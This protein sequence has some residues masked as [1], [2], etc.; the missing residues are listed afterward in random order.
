MQ[1]NNNTPMYLLDARG[2][3]MHMLHRGSDMDSLLSE[4]GKRQINTAEFGMHNFI[5]GYLLP[6]LKE[7]PPQN[8][9]AVWDGGKDY[10]SY[11][12]PKY[13]ANRAKTRDAVETE[14]ADKLQNYAKRLLAYLGILNISVKGVEADD[15]L[16][17]LCQ[18]YKGRQKAVYTVDADLLQLDDECTHVFLREEVIKGDYKGTPLNLIRLQKSIVGDSSDGYSGVNRIGEV[19]WQLMVDNYGFDGLEELEHIVSTQNFEELRQIAEE[20]GCKV[21]NRLYE[22]RD[23]WSLMYDLARLHPELCYGMTG[24]KKVEPI[25]YKRVPDHAQVVKILEAAKC[26]NFFP[27]FED[28]W[29]REILV[30]EENIEGVFE[31]MDSQLPETPYV[32]FDYETWD[33]VKHPEF[34]K[35]KAKSAKKGYVDVLSSEIAG[36]SFNFGRNL[37]YTAYFCVDHALT[38]NVSK[39]DVRAIL[40]EVQNVHKVPLI[41]H[42]A[43]FEEQIS[44]QCLG[45]EWEKPHDTYLMSRYADENREAGLKALSAEILRYN[46]T[47]YAD[48]LAAAG[49]DSMEKLTGKQALSYGCDD[50]L[51]TTH[52]YQV[53]KLTQQMEGSWD[54]YEEYNTRTVNVLNRAKEI[55][56]NLDFDRLEELRKQDAETVISGMAELRG[57]LEIH[58]Q[59]RNPE[60]AEA[61]FKLER[62]V[63]RAKITNKNPDWSSSKLN[64]KLEEQRLKWVAASQYVPYRE[65]RASVDFMGT[66]NQLNRVI[67]GIGVEGEAAP[68]PLKSISLKEIRRWLIAL[69]DSGIADEQVLRFAN[70]LGESAAELKHRAGESWERLKDFCLPILSTDSKVIKEGDEL[71]LNSPPQVTELLYCK[72]ALPVREHTKKQRGSFRDVQGFHGSPATDEDAIKMAIAQDCEEGSWKRR[73]LE[74]ILEIKGCLTRESLYYSKYPLW[75]HPKTGM[76]HPNIRDCGT[77]TR[78]PTGGDPNIL[79]V[80]KGPLRSVFIPRYNDHV[81]VAIDFSG[82][83]LRITGAE[84]NDPTLIEAYTGAEPVLNS[85]GMLK[86]Q[87][88]D[89]HSVTGCAFAEEIFRRQMG[90]KYPDGL[91]QIGNGAVDYNQFKHI[92]DCQGDLKL[93][94]SHIL[95]VPASFDLN[96]VT[97]AALL[98]RKMAKTVNFL[99]IYGGSAMT[100]AKGL[101]VP[102]EFAERLMDMVFMLYGRLQPW[103]SE[104]TKFARTHGYVQTAY[105]NRRHCTTDIVSRDGS[106]RSRM[107]RQVIN[108]TIQSCAADI[109]HIVETDMDRTGLL[110]ET[111]AVLIAPIYDEVLASVPMRNLFEYCERMQDIMNVT[112]PGH[113]IPQLAEVSVGPNWYEV[114]EMGDRPSEQELIQVVDRFDRLRNVA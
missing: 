112:P 105:G 56:I 11:L 94:D 98:V 99:I 76:L 32:A 90:S 49:V 6:I 19:A 70:L 60:G 107:E 42:N 68:E 79:Q 35:A 51:V 25:F 64:V 113:V 67:L 3:V 9:I 93:L 65:V 33:T 108:S 22:R 80:A 24:T 111:G 89:I 14:Q 34:K 103:Q 97:K 40:N 74:L 43:A 53:L 28:I 16:A 52:L 4:D 58:C 109:L 15:V 86:S 75:V 88:R 23:E 39:E 54:F 48:T 1:Q 5:E 10:R 92:L 100:L 72:L 106:K 73:A 18:V 17:L 8:I 36:A 55:G 69:R 29:P 30:T 59:E 61:L 101:G 85:F 12:Y 38:L 84:A 102:I 95:D 78:R 26:L 71:N 2:L 47:S 91:F 77:D 46:Q 7:V 44:N 66:P 50:S 110:S 31:L 114:V 62:K 87:H 63:V 96:A 83:E 27:E 13:K 57:L 41:A 45:F 81:I 37:Q 104:T 82:Q 21:L 20:S